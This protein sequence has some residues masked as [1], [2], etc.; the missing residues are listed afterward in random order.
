[1]NRRL[2]STAMALTLLTTNIPVFAADGPEKEAPEA[3]PVITAEAETVTA[4][5]GGKAEDGGYTVSVSASGRC[6]AMLA[7]AVYDNEGGRLARV[8]RRDVTVSGEAEAAVTVERD[9]ESQYVLGFFWEKGSLR[10]LAAMFDSRTGPSEDEEQIPLSA[11]NVWATDQQKGQGHTVGDLLDGSADTYLAGQALNGKPLYIYADLGGV[12]DL[13]RVE[14]GF[15]PVNGERS[16]ALDI[17]SSLDGEAYTMALED[18]HTDRR[19]SA[20]VSYGLGV[21]AAYLKIAVYG[22]DDKNNS[23]NENGWVQMN[24]LAAYGKPDLSAVETPLS[25][26]Y[27]GRLGRLSSSP[28]AGYW[29]AYALDEETYTDYTPSTGGDLMAEYA[30]L[31]DGAGLGAGNSALRLH[32]GADRYS[33]SGRGSIGAFR[34]LPAPSGTDYTVKFKLFIPSDSENINW[35]GLNLLS[36]RVTGG[37]DLKP[38]AAVQLR[39]SDGAK[40]K[41]VV[42][43]LTS[44]QYNEGSPG[45]AFDSEF[46][47]GRPWDVTLKV[48]PEG[49]NAEITID[50][51]L[52]SE[53]RLM[54]YNVTDVERVNNQT[55]TNTAVKYLAL[56]TGAGGK[57]DMYLDDLT[58]SYDGGRASEAMTVYFQDFESDTLEEAG[59]R[60]AVVKKNADGTTGGG[61]IGPSLKAETAASNAFGGHVL[62]LTD[63][64]G[65]DGLVVG[66][67]LY[68]PDNNNKYIIKWKMRDYQPGNYSGFSLASGF[69]LGMTDTEHPMALQMRNSMQDGNSK[70]QYNYY[71]STRFNDGDFNGFMALGGERLRADATLSFEITVNPVTHMLDISISD[72][73]RTVTRTHAFETA[74]S[75]GGS[76]DWSGKRPDTLLFHTG[77]GSKADWIIDDI[78]VID[79]GVEDHSAD[80]AVMGLVRLESV[81]GTGRY[82]TRNGEDRPTNTESADPNRTR[83][84]ERP[85]LADSRGVSLESADQ[86]GLYLYAEETHEVNHE[87]TLALKEPDGSAQD[88]AFATFYK[89]T[90]EADEAWHGSQKLYVPIWD[91]DRCINYDGGKDCNYAISRPS[92]ERNGRFYLR[93]E[94]V[95]YVSDN[96]KGNA[97][98]GQWWTNLPWKDNNPT[99]DSYNFTALIDH[100]NVIVENGELLLKATKID[101]GDWVQDKSGETGIQYNNQYGKNKWYKWAGRVGVVS[102]QNKVYNKEC[103]IEGSFKQPDS[104][105]GYWNA[106]WL[107]GRDSW[108]PEID[109]FE[110]LSSKYG[111]TSWNSNIHGQGDKNNLFGTSSSNGVNLTSGYHTFTMDWG[112]NYLRLYVDGRLFQHAENHST[113]DYQKYMRLILNTGVGGWENEPDGNMKWN[114]GLRCQWIRSFQY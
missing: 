19:F 101:G 23:W 5:L 6:E 14:L 78:E 86:P 67:P 16:Y 51:G 10:P 59:I 4:R 2:L 30:A 89:Q 104:P 75:Y 107:A 58:L 108:P 3:E 114:D 29:F 93:S 45:R 69:N 52:V 17:F 92:P 31:P 81:F 41:A 36:D 11:A 18:Q 105:I 47:L 22:Y 1:M 113:L 26:N 68:P 100:R 35:A 87:Y 84:I 44:V 55:W 94:A 97:L 64:T 57:L 61:S 106:F 13:S 91:T 28:S 62:K 48:S 102:I 9:P 72:G 80:G 38:A 70:I 50:D 85:G 88:K 111:H 8:E 60:Q 74:G 96:F 66:V 112:Y 82:M 79:T 56:N 99:N 20:P 95:N 15:N 109:I 42:N 54:G 39:L 103:L 43:A 53:T 32:D 98:N 27:T 76:E 46:T 37:A 25:E 12:W 63:S 34:E 7:A 77:A 73:T 21:R 40:G 24:T 65:N 83:F 110:F 33:G 71:A 90:A 49:K